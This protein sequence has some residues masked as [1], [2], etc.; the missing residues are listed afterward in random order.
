MPSP[1]AG[2]FPSRAP[3][4]FGNHPSIKAGRGPIAH[5]GGVSRSFENGKGKQGATPGGREIH[6]ALKLPARL[7]RVNSALIPGSS[8]AE[9]RRISYWKFRG[10]GFNQAAA[11]PTAKILDGHSYA[12]EELAE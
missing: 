3:A 6:P 12:D 2:R 5:C 4:A 7:R 8:S 10:S 9:F 11:K 1:R